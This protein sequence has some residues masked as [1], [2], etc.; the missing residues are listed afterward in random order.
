MDIKEGRGV[1]R[2]VLYDEHVIV[3]YSMPF[4]GGILRRLL[5]WASM[6]TE[7]DV[8]KETEPTVDSF[9]LTVCETLKLHHL[10]AH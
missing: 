8:V 6:M 4:K 2:F 5:E 10:N 3:T 9:C 7:C 1:V